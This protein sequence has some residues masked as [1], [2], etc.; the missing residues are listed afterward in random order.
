MT[1]FARIDHAAGAKKVG[2]ELRPT[3]LLL[4]GNPQVGTLLMQC[5]QSIGL[6]LPLKALIWQDESGQTWFSYDGSEYLKEKYNVE[7][8]Y[9]VFEKVEGALNNFAKAATSSE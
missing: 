3:E 8:C 7:G 1:V 5:Q 6:D 4:F 2:K 9:L